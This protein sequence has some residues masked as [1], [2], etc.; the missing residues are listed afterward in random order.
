MALRLGQHRAVTGALGDH[1]GW[2]FRREN[3]PRERK[4]GVWVTHT[5]GIAVVFNPTGW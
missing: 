4:S 1:Q 5:D 3:C 2:K